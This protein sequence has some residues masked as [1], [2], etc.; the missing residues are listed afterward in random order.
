MNIR[1]IAFT[2]TL[3]AVM[4]VAMAGGPSRSV[5]LN[6]HV[7][8]GGNE[9]YMTLTSR[10]EVVKRDGKFAVVVMYWNDH[11]KKMMEGSQVQLDANNQFAPKGMRWIFTL[12]PSGHLTWQER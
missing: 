9:G 3:G 12:T 1:H 11:H 7:L 5:P 8:A 6:D 2:I 4:S 10:F